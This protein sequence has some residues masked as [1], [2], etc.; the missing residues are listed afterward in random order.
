MCMN[1]YCGVRNIIKRRKNN[2]L[3]Y[4]LKYISFY[5]GVK[6]IEEEF[7]SRLNGFITK[8]DAIYF[9]YSKRLSNDVKLIVFLQNLALQ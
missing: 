2:L 3:C 7:L 8:K 4:F 6:V 9:P 1:V 5:V